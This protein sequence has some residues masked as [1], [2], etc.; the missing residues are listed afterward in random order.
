ML[1]FIFNYALQHFKAYCATWIRLSDFS[2]PGVSMRV[3]TRQYPA[4]EDGT[5]GV[6]CLIIF[7]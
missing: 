6:K 1:C 4:A 3:T 7:A 2:P 5:L